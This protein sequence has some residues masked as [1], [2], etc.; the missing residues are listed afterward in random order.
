MLN[1]TC[2]V[3][4]DPE[5][6]HLAIIAEVAALYLGLGGEMMDGKPHYPSDLYAAFA[7]KSLGLP[8]FALFWDFGRCV[9]TQVYNHPAP[10][11]YF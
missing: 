9:A 5:G 8:D 2:C 6:C 10:H 1:G 4:A 11:H 3:A 7:A